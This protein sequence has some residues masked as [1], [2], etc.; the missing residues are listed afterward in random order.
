MD[1]NFSVDSWFLFSQ[2]YFSSQT[3]TTLHSEFWSYFS[4]GWLRTS[5]VLS[6][7]HVKTGQA[8]NEHATK[9]YKG[10]RDKWR[11]GIIPQGRVIRRIPST[12]YREHRSRTQ[13]GDG[14]A[15]RQLVNWHS[16][17]IPYIWP[18]HSL[19]SLYWHQEYFPLGISRASRHGLQHFIK[20]GAGMEAN[21]LPV[22]MNQLKLETTLHGYNDLAMKLYS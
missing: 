5:G 12:Q 14:K 11:E 1:L 18:G 4:W 7:A 15:E 3:K 20:P 16:G 2:N 9:A 13:R 19:F 17:S 21:W 10:I 22:G 6:R 8:E